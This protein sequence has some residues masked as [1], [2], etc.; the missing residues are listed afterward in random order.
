MLARVYS[1]AVYG[2]DA[3]PVETGK[4]RRA[5]AGTNLRHPEGQGK[6]MRRESQRSMGIPPRVGADF[7]L[8][9]GRLFSST[10]HFFWMRS[11]CLNLNT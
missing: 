3:Y 4:R 6:R 8:E 11:G 9:W 7:R 2:V 1:G 5:R 10:H